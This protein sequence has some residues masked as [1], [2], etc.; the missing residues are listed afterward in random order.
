MAGQY[1]KAHVPKL[2]AQLFHNCMYI[3]TLQDK[4]W[5]RQ[6]GILMV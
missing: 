3:I 6:Q 5:Q 1:T 2:R 4:Q